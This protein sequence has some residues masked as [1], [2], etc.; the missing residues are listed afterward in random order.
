MGQA[1]GV[2]LAQLGHEVMF[3]ARRPQLAQASAELVGHSQARAS[4]NDEAAAHGELLFWTV[5]DPRPGSVL[6]DQALLE[7]KVVIDINNRDYALDVKRVSGSER[8]WP[9]TSA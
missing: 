5:R 6:V 7:G 8:E 9:T 4:S 3:G 1:M 2:R